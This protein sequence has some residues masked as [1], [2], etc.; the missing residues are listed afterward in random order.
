MPDDQA[1]SAR[2]K[3][4]TEGRE[5]GRFVARLAILSLI[6]V[7]AACKDNPSRSADSSAAAAPTTSAAVATTE[8]L[9]ALGTEPFWALDID[10]TGLRFTTPD[11]TSGK[12]F[13]PNAPTPMAG[14]TLVW[15][16]E[17]DL[18]AVHVRIWPEPCSD[19]MSD[20]SYPWTAIVRVAGTTYRGCADRRRIIAP[21]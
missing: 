17:S 16:A 5:Y 15:M 14:D 18:T 11:D 21:S 20:R 9:R 1:Q 4:Q 2:R 7:L 10:S 3:A 13:P 19:G 8:P 12:R 6:L